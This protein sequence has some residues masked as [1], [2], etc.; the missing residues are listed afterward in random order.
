MLSKFKDLFY[1]EKVI[2]KNGKSKRYVKA[3]WLLLFSVLLSFGTINTYGYDLV[4]HIMRLDPTKFF[5]WLEG[6]VLFL[7]WILA[8]VALKN[9][10]GWGGIVASIILSA[11]TIGGLIQEGYIDLNKDTIGW[12]INIAVALMIWLGLIGSRIWLSIT[13]QYELAGGIDDSADDHDD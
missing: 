1:T 5:S 12:S 2:K 11:L 9:S 7:L 4:H 10:V 13:G 3:S 8:F 6:F